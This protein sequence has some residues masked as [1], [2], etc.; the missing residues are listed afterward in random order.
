MGQSLMFNI[1]HWST[2]QIQK[3]HFSK[4]M[5]V[6]HRT[7]RPCCVMSIQAV[8]YLLGGMFYPVREPLMSQSPHRNRSSGVGGWGN[9]IRPTRCTDQGTSYCFPNLLLPCRFGGCAYQNT[10]WASSENW[11]QTDPLLPRLDTLG[12]QC[13]RPPA[14]HT[15]T[16]LNNMVAICFW[17][18]V[19]WSLSDKVSISV[20][21]CDFSCCTRIPDHW[22]DLS[23]LTWLKL[24]IKTFLWSCWCFLWLISIC[25][26]KVRWICSQRPQWTTQ[27]SYYQLESDVTMVDKQ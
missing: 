23:S 25:S 24:S 3:T 10:K 9:V 21:K 11:Q 26:L 14:V 2:E 18:T 19:A 7:T 1:I 15:L 6:L 8:H 27:H 22:G 16:G 20:T 4:N 17:S 5:T 13:T 12:H